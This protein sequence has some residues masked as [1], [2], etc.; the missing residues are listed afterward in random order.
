MEKLAEVYVNSNLEIKY[1]CAK[2]NVFATKNF[3]DLE[4]H[5]KNK[6]K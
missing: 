1:V 3:Y 4:E 2:C 5:V 6:H